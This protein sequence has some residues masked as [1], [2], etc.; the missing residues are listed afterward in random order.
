MS[1]NVLESKCLRFEQVMQFIW[2]LLLEKL[3]E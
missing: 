2:N 1:N 3:G